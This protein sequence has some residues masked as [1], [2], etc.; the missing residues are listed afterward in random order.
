MTDMVAAL[1]CGIFYLLIFIVKVEMGA[2]CS[3]F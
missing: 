2:F 3:I 1:C